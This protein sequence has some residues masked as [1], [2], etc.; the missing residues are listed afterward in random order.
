[1]GATVQRPHMRQSEIAITNQMIETG[2][3]GSA[4]VMGKGSTGFGDKKCP[5]R[6][7]GAPMCRHSPS[8]RNACE[9]KRQKRR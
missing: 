3:Y 1:M 6:P 4:M 7:N 8:N 9:Y 2:A 5:H